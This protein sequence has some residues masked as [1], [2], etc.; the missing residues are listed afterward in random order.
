[1]LRR[2]DAAE[3]AKLEEAFLE[4]ARAGFRRMFAEQDQPRLRTFTERED[5]ACEAGDRLSR[6]LLEAHLKQDEL[7][8]AVEIHDCPDCGRPTTGLEDEP[9]PERDLVTRRG[10][11][12]LAR[13]ERA[14]PACR[15]ALFPPRP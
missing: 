11:V 12:H 15:R 2:L 13:P 9:L 6:V 5:R 7:A 3:R 4:E 8:Q 1:M 10:P 14:C